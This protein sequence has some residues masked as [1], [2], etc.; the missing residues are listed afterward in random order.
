LQ[1]EFR[2]LQMDEAYMRAV[3]ALIAFSFLIVASIAA[4]TIKV[5]PYQ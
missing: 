5:G 2:V 4:Q 1:S 3:I